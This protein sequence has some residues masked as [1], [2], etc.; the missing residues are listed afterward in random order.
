MNRNLLE[1]AL[2]VLVRSEFPCYGAGIID[3]NNLLISKALKDRPLMFASCTEVEKVIK[4]ILDNRDKVVN[5][6]EQ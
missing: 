1:K 6:W 3:Q 2:C 5:N 4:F